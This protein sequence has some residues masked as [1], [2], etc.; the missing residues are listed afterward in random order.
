MHP[1]QVV[2]HGARDVHGGS[3]V[4][5]PIDWDLLDALTAAQP[6]DEELRVEE[7]LVVASRRN[8]RP[9]GIVGHELEAALMIVE[10]AVEEPSD[11]RVEGPGEDFSLE[12]APASSSIG[13]I[14][15]LGHCQRST[16][17][18]A[19]KTRSSAVTPQSACFGAMDEACRS[20]R[21]TLAPA[22]RSAA[23][24]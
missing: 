17:A 13:R 2:D 3:E 22:W 24:M 18:V 19:M 11:E 10:R 7:P 12:L 8:E 21:S 9:A 4:L 14:S 5:D 1:D 6:E 20:T 15:M 16:S 23:A